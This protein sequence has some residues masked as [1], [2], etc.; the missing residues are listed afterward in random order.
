MLKTPR[1]CHQR[2]DIWKI[3]QSLFNPVILDAA[4]DTLTVQSPM[5]AGKTE[6]RRQIISPLKRISPTFSGPNHSLNSAPF[7]Y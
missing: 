7:A 6:Q 2:Q 5:R 1:R 3:A 4:F